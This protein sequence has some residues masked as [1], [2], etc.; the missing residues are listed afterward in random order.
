MTEEQKE[1]SGKIFNPRHPQLKAIKRIAHNLCTDYN[2]TYEDDMEERSEILSKL[3]KAK[4]ENVYFQGP[5]YFNYGSHTTIGDAFFGNY[6]ICIS[7]D[8]EVIIG[9]HVMFGPNCTLVT[10]EHPLIANERRYMTD[11]N[12]E[13]FG[14]CFAKPI[15]IEDDVWLGGG[16]TVCGGVTIGKGAVIGAGSVVTKDIPANTVAAGVPCKVIREITEEDS[17]KKKPWLFD[18]QE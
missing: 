12:G 7:D 14:P 13:L 10:P 2:K 3:L 17:I 1:L 6:N 9:D 16:V 11:E 5:I 4:G 18:T 15:I 8:A